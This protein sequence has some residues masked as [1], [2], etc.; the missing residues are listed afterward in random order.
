VLG[1]NSGQFTMTATEP[2]AEQIRALVA[3]HR[4]SPG[5]LLVVLHAVQNALGFIPPS[6]VAVIAH[7]L[8]L[9]RAEV[10]GVITFYHHFR[11]R[12]A[13]KHVVQVCMAESCQAVGGRELAAHARQRIGTSKGHAHGSANGDA[14][15][16]NEVEL[17]PV[18][19]LGLCA[20]S[21]AVMVSGELHGRVT[22]ERFD[23]LLAACGGGA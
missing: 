20:C 9:S 12:P 22:I 11:Q 5:P 7:E 23:E 16:D 3:P 1:Y 10:H 17:Q 14:H 13:A 8:N 2:N 21:P 18:Y 19:C 4:Q 6:S 15:G